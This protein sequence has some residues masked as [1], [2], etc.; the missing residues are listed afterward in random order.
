MVPEI[1]SRQTYFFVILD[2]FLP[3]Y[4]PMASENQ[5]FQKMEKNTCRHHNFT[6]INDSHMMCGSSDMDCNRQNF[7]SFWTIFAFTPLTTQKMKILKKWKTC[8]EILSFYT[9]V[10]EMKILWGMVL[11]ITGTNDRIFCHFGPF[12]ALLP[13]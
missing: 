13:P 11:E 5:I 6:N 10:T 2:R 9:G 3:F 8:L 7:L 12:F 4:P 1:W